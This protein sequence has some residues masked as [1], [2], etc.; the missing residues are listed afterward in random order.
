MLPDTAKL[1]VRRSACIW[2]VRMT[3]WLPWLTCKVATYKNFD[4]ADFVVPTYRLCNAT[5][6]VSR[7]WR[8]A[9]AHAAVG[10]V[11]SD[12]AFLSLRI[13][14]SRNRTRQPVLANSVSRVL[15]VVDHARVDV[16]RACDGRACIRGRRG[17]RWRRRRGWSPRKRRRQR[18][19]R[20]RRRWRTG[21]R[22]RHQVHL[23]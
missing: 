21:R 6:K 20:L 9:V 10:E 11:R 4:P 18:R 5:A 1:C 17:R 14:R 13:H 12:S 15:H 7:G 23:D 19:R 2:R 8:V 3:L 16:Q 22:V